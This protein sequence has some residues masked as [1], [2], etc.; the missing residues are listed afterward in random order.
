MR[1]ILDVRC[2]YNAKANLHIY[3]TMTSDHVETSFITFA[4]FYADNIHSSF[5]CLDN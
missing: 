5:T 4:N 3:L 1:I 2:V